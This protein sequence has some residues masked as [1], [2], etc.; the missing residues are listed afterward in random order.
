MAHS[1]PID[2]STHNN[3]LNYL[4]CPMEDQGLVYLHLEQE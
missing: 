3:P 4:G 2:L 1:Q